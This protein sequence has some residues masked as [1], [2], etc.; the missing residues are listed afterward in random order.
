MKDW[1]IRQ[2][3]LA[4]LGLIVAT[5][6]AMGGLAYLRLTNIEREAARLQNDSLPGFYYS[7]YIKDALWESYSIS[8]DYVRV[9]DGPERKQLEQDL[10]G[11]RSRLDRLILQYESTIAAT[12][13]RRQFDAFK[14]ALAAY[15]A[16]RD[17]LLRTIADQGD[18]PELITRLKTQV[19]PAFSTA[20][21]M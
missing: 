9:G 17:G 2:R 18:S 6:I 10:Q 14:S 15:R 8:Q 4:S 16:T 5:V 7:A 13:D 19:Y 20:L 11:N 21:V 3:I 12:D 1:S